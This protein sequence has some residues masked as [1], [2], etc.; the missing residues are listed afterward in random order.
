MSYLLRQMF[1]LVRLLNSDTGTNSI[2]AGIAC[3]LIL[4][5][6]PVFSLQTVLV[7]LVLFLFRIQV[8]AALVSA[9]FFAFAAWVLDPLHHAVGVALLESEA[10][11]PL[12]TALYHMPLVPLTRFYNSVTLGAGVVSLVLAPFVFLLSRRLI[13]TYRVTVVARLRE[14]KLW[15]L[16]RATPV[17]KWYQRY[18]EL[19]G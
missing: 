12:F 2:A 4:G 10:L 5:F 1:E 15:K 11:T 3:G 13:D 7:I 14:M 16:W 18:A 19:Y 6:A 8:G 17:Y 9:F